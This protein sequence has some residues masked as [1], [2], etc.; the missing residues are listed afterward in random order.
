VRWSQQLLFT[1]TVGPVPPATVQGNQVQNGG[2]P[3]LSFPL[4]WVVT[5]PSLGLPGLPSSTHSQP[6]WL[7][8]TCQGQQ[9]QIVS[10]IESGIHAEEWAGCSWCLHKLALHHCGGGCQGHI[11]CKLIW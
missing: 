4:T 10:C 11:K 5:Y 3:A 2:T 9:L 6:S 7:K 1:N 8:T